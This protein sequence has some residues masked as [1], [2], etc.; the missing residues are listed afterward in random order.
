MTTVMDIPQLLKSKEVAELLGVSAWQVDELRRQ[1]LL[2]SVAV[3]QR[4]YRYMP[5]DVME[6]IR[7]RRG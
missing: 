2:K 3:G 4:S 7:R 5:E 6:F 1:D